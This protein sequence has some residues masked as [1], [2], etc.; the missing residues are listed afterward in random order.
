MNKKKEKEN[1]DFSGETV[2]EAS[3]RKYRWAEQHELCNFA[4]SRRQ[5]PWPA[6]SRQHRKRESVCIY[7]AE[8]VEQWMR[9]YWPAVVL[10]SGNSAIFWTANGFITSS[11]LLPPLQKK[12]GKKK[13]ESWLVSAVSPRLLLSLPGN[14]L[15]GSL[16]F[17]ATDYSL[18]TLSL[19]H[20]FSC[21]ANIFHCLS[22][23]L[24]LP[25][26]GHF[27][28]QACVANTFGEKPRAARCE[29]NPVRMGGAERR[30]ER[31]MD[32]SLS[33]VLSFLVLDGCI[34]LSKEQNKTKNCCS[35]HC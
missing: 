32:K 16:L 31:K 25:F 30:V 11:S 28:P 24:Y 15:R 34:A 10:Q 35:S 29:R 12:E 5:N 17:S 7:T 1:L 19:T 8:E 4:R 18:D 13:G 33:E 23:M 6:R 27:A 22:F 3:D 26:F 9:L 20:S 2:L 21:F 14:A